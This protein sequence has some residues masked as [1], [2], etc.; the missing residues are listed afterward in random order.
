MIKNNI[1]LL[2]IASLSIVACS[3][4]DESVTDVPVTAGSANFSK[5]V[6][7]GDSFA[8][9]FSDGALFKKGQENSYPS[10]LAQQFKQAGGGDFKIPFMNDNIGGFTTAALGQNPRLVFNGVGPVSLG[11][12]P[13]NQAPTT[14]LLPALTGGFNNYGVPGAKSFHLLAPNFGNPAGIGTTANPYFVHFA[15]NT[16]NSVLQDALAQNPT[17]FSLWIGGNDVLGYARA[18][19]VTKAQD[20]QYGD[21]I[22]PVAMFNGA[23]DNLINS[24]TNGGKKGVIANLPYINTLPFFTTVGYN[25]VSLTS[26]QATALNSAYAAY[27]GG[28]VAAKNLGLITEAERVARTITFAAGKNPV[29]IID[30]YLTDITAVNPGLIKMRQTTKDD[31]IVLSS[32]NV[33][34]QT[35]LL[36]GNGTQFP[37]QDRWVVSKKEVEEI[38]VATDA[39]NAKILAV[40]NDKGLAFVDAK[41]IMEQL[42]NG[43]VRF[44]NYHVS[45]TYVT[46]GVFSLD[47]IHPGARGYALIANKFIEAINAKY[48][49]TLKSLDLG[50]YSVQYPAS[51]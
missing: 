2:L 7:L 37:L 1:K 3:K 46:G 38:K 28:L 13:Y 10:L 26:A 15:S 9:G 16:T 11:Q 33:S 34:A 8:A 45:A 4:D 44:G 39:Y 48:G 51:L 14:N 43:G 20:A 27:N 30:E 21:D 12:S 50:Q 35:H 49:S 18:G 25:P 17:F 41:A 23:Y 24:L 29:V 32:Q 19:G 36:A 6:A 22:T 42:V 5:Y 47:G 31:F 40:A